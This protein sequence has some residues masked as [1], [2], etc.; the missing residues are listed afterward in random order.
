MT[1]TTEP[2]G[3]MARKHKRII[4]A[5]SITLA[6]ILIA[7]GTAVALLIP[8]K[9]DPAPPVSAPSTSAPAPSASPAATPEPAETTPPATT[10]P[11]QPT[12]CRTIY[13]AGYPDGYEGEELNHESMTGSDI[14]R[15]EAI[16]SIR[17]ALPGIECHWGLATEGGVMNAVNTVD[18]ATQ[19]QA[20][21]VMKAND[22]VCE[23]WLEGT[24]CRQSETLPDEDAAD[25]AETIWTIAEE[26]YFA[27]G[28]WV[29]TWFAGTASSIRHYSDGIYATIW[30]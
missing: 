26:H 30:K 9:A 14:S 16:E 23:P 3:A 1:E 21:E 4:I 11:A 2:A 13:P 29:S 22:H 18:S 12:D 7:G 19:A 20:I 17:E 6:L 25:G 24:L 10:G 28:L 27:D 8:P 5:V 15:Y